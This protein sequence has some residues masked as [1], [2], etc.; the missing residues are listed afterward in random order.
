MTALSKMSGREISGLCLLTTFSMGEMMGSENMHLEKDFT[1]LLWLCISINDTLFILQ[2]TST[3]IDILEEWVKRFMSVTKIMIGPQREMIFQIGLWMAKFHG[4]KHY[5]H[6]IR[7]FGFPLNFFG[8]YL[9]SFLKDRLK[10]PSKRVNGQLHRLKHDIL[11]R[12]YETRQFALKRKLVFANDTLHTENKQKKLSKVVHINVTKGISTEI[13]FEGMIPDTRM[14]PSTSPDNLGI[15]PA[16]YQDPLT[17]IP[18][19]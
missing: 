19:C 18:S 3:C 14:L 2:Y 13:D 7:N 6:L 12:S 1:L 4:M 5:P 16:T 10:R 11:T 8:E 15:S 9:E 17:M